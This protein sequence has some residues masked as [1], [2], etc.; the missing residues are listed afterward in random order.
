MPGFMLISG[1]FSFRKVENKKKLMNSYRKS[2]ERY[3]LPFFSWFILISVLLLGN[4]ERNV[5][6]GLDILVWRVDG[7]LW[8][9]WVVFVLSLIMG[10]CNLVLGKVRG[11]KNSWYLLW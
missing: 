6:K 10:L 2:V 3:L 8:F 5:L 11:I 1:Y 4:Y 9:I 7:G